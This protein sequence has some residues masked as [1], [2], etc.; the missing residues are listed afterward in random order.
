M[1]IHELRAK[2]AAALDPLEAQR[3]ALVIQLDTLVAKPDYDQAVDDAEFDRIQKSVTTIDTRKKT[4]ADFFD[5]EIAR[6]TEELERAAKAAKPVEGQVYASAETSPYANDSIAAKLQFGSSK[7]LILGAAVKMLAAGGGGILNARQI[8]KEVYGEAHPVTKALLASV[9]A[10]GG[11]FVPPDYMPDYVEILRAKAQVRAA[12]PRTLPMPRGT[13][14]L[15]AQT[16][17]AQASYGPEDRRIP[18]SQPGT[19]ALVASY[20]KEVGLVPISNDLMRFADPAIDAFVRDDLVKVM[21]LRE[22]LAFLIGDGTQ[23][24]PRGFL[25]FANA[26]AVATGGTPGNWLTTGNSTLAVGG[27]FIT[28]NETYTLATVATEIGGAANKL[29][30]ANVPDDKR[31]W[32]MH[33]RARNY[34]YDVQNSLGQYVYREELDAGTLRK[35]KVYTTTQLP[36][37]LADATS[38]QTDCTLVFLVEMTEA[39]LFDAMTLELAVSREGSYYDANSVQQNDETLVR[40][41]AEHDFLMRHDAA[42]AVIQNVR[43]AP[44]IS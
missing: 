33:P 26:R 44:A 8:A 11:F 37:N 20:K 43:W 30:T 32:F 29:D 9:G 42:V 21:A 35:C 38:A 5:A 13:M 15:P 6:E 17:A 36:A 1:S 24:S 12:G 7:S 25:S 3:K 40:A 18:V 27:N 39:M 23:D 28:S 4:F 22:D 10:S 14:R 41:I 2:R 34:L 31:V 19:G 16:S